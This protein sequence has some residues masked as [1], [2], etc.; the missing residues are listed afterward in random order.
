MSGAPATA[1]LQTPWG[2]RIPNR[3]SRVRNGVIQGAAAVG[4]AIG[5][6]IFR[7]SPTSPNARTDIELKIAW[8]WSDP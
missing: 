2:G 7:N 5:Q 8:V 4:V 1:H 3:N 6:L